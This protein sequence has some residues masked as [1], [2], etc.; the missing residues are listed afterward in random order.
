MP[1]EPVACATAV[2]AARPRL[3]H[4]GTAF[5]EFWS[6]HREAARRRCLF[7]MKGRTEDAEEALSRVALAA[8]RHALAEPRLLLNERAWVMRLAANACFDLYREQKRRR[9]TSL[10]ELAVAPR[11]AASL[12][13][14][15]PEQACLEAELQCYLRGC[16]EALPARLRASAWLRLLE[17]ASYPEIA[18]VLGITQDNARKRVQEAR[19]ILRRAIDAYRRTGP[20]HTT[21]VRTV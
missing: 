15:S 1:L 18:R 8:L 11:D 13:C 19:S 5:G 21:R 4:A 10:E 2:V 7:L 12:A 3:D 16:I 6:R 20:L 14:E 17:E 9:E